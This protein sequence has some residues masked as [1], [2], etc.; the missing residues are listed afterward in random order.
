MIKIAI[1]VLLAVPPDSTAGGG[2]N[3]P[4]MGKPADCVGGC[5]EVRM[6]E[7]HFSAIPLTGFITLYQRAFS[8][9]AGAGCPSYPSCS[10][11]MKLTIRDYG[12]FKGLVMGVERLL[13]EGGEV[14]HGTWIRTCDDRW[15]V[16]DPPEANALWAGRNPQP[17]GQ[18]K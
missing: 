12:T 2:M 1:L 16:Y 4:P 9:A 8:S 11:Y 18:E 6:S 15:L 14:A 5:E 13:H 7:V 3:G 17:D 10:R